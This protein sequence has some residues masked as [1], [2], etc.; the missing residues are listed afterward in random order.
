MS[1]RLVIIFGAFFFLFADTAYSD[2]LLDKLKEAI[3]TEVADKVQDA[4]ETE[5][6]TDQHQVGDGQGMNVTDP[7][8]PDVY[9]IQIGMSAE[10]VVAALQYKHSSAVV[11]HSR[12]DRPWGEAM[13]GGRYKGKESTGVIAINSQWYCGDLEGW[14]CTDVIEF[15]LEYLPHDEYRRLRV[16]L[17]RP[18]GEDRSKVVSVMFDHRVPNTSQFSLEDFMQRKYGDRDPN[19]TASMG[20]ASQANSRVSR[21]ASTRS[22]SRGTKPTESATTRESVA[23]S[24]SGNN[25]RPWSV[26]SSQY[27]LY[28]VG[29]RG[30]A[31]V[32]GGSATR[33]TRNTYSIFI[34]LDK[35]VPKQWGRQHFEASDKQKQ[36]EINERPTTED[37]F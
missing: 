10:Q 37:P 36:D 3:E 34:E 31:I 26:K 9:G 24:F 19:S 16:E 7:T 12:T 1:S 4:D 13:S 35:N 5:P 33:S 32:A 27:G 18:F 29:Y 14:H 2:G 21:H 11:A 8:I 20:G 25:I 15:R 17:A 28:Q 6:D 23:P 22:R 30:S